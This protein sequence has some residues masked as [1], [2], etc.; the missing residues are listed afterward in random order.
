MAL[1]DEF[2]KKAVDTTQGA[3]RGAKDLADIMRLNSFIS[4]E[5]KQITNLLIQIG[6]FVYKHNLETADSTLLSLCNAITTANER[7]AKHQSDIQRIKGETSCPKCGQGIPLTQSF[8]SNCGTSV[9]SEAPSI[10]E[11]EAQSESKSCVNCGE[12]IETT[13]IFCPKCGQKVS[14]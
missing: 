10:P 3:V 13:T 14:E 2:K 8:C 1:F 9:K 7:I 4:D 6:E 12:T 5:Q 11:P